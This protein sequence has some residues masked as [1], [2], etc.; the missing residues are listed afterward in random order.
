MTQR[1]FIE[2]MREH[3][4]WLKKKG[5]KKADFTGESLCD[6]N[7][8]VIDL[9]DDDPH[10]IPGNLFKG[11]SFVKANLSG[12][13]MTACNFYKANFSGANL[14]GVKANCCNFGSADMS[15]TNLHSA[16]LAG[17]KLEHANLCD[18][19]LTYANLSFSDLRFAHLSGITGNHLDLTGAWLDETRFL[20]AKLK[21]A[22]FTVARMD[23][24]ID[25]GLPSR[26]PKFDGAD[27]TEA[28]FIKTELRDASFNCAN[29]TRTVFFRA[30]FCA[31]AGTTK[32]G[33]QVM[34]GVTSF[35]EAEVDNTMLNFSNVGSHFDFTGVD[36]SKC[37]M[38]NALRKILKESSKE[39]GTSST[40]SMSLF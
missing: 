8:L 28:K 34:P 23:G 27:L 9:Q 4:K 35:K 2:V 14:T 38:N 29:L 11:V 13:D 40:S 25:E 20:Y 30:N 3:I 22:D 24:E 7:F 32:D 18:A 5:G 12:A 19:T 39:S 33:K 17:A 15:G 1:Q 21:G 31:A 10:L 16:D 37:Q 6:I 36:L 26:G